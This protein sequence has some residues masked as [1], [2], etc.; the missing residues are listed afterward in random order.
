MVGLEEAPGDTGGAKNLADKEENWNEPPTI[1]TGP[2]QVPADG[3]PP[4]G[5]ST[6]RI[7]RDN[8]FKT[9]KK[10]L[11]FIDEAEKDKTV[12]VRVDD[13]RSAILM[14][15]GLGTIVVLL[16]LFTI[17]PGLRSV[18]MGL[19]IIADLLLGA[20]I[21]W[22]VIIRFGI[23]RSLDPRYAVLCFQL[24]LGTG[25][26]FAYFSIN[27]ALT[28]LSMVFKWGPLAGS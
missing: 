4:S 13:R 27:I 11:A 21:I 8:I 23:L 24:L 17:N 5:R 10:T 20:A 7:V 18:C 14:W 25:I 3:L 15:S 1:G 26:M 16:T 19:G 6:L 28:F 12:K 2:G 9:A 22:Y